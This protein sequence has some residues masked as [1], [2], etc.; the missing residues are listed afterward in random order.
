MKFLLI[1]QIF[2]LFGCSTTPPDPNNFC[3]R[4]EFRRINH[5]DVPGDSYQETEVSVT[6]PVANW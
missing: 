2:I 5:Q 6:C 1:I 3:G 4:P